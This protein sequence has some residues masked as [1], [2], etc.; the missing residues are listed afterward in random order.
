MEDTVRFATGGCGC[1]IE[2]PRERLSDERFVGLLD[3]YF[4]LVPGDFSFARTRSVR[5]GETASACCADL[6][7]RVDFGDDGELSDVFEFVSMCCGWTHVRAVD[8]P[9][10]VEIRLEYDE[11]AVKWGFA[12]CGE[13]RGR[14]EQPLFFSIDGLELAAGD[15]LSFSWATR[16]CFADTGSWSG[17]IDGAGRID[18]FGEVDLPDGWTVGEDDFNPWDAL[19]P[20][21]SEWV[22]EAA[23]AAKERGEGTCGVKRIMREYVDATRRID[24]LGKARLAMVPGL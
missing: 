2:V 14:A 19:E 7:A 13:N 15:G 20:A 5:G 16:D 24:A 9:A 23:A 6:W 1:A 22:R 11:G 4:G 17:R 8:E 12:F 10:G 3:R 21:V 18:G